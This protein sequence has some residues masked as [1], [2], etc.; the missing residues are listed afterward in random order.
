MEPKS[1]AYLSPEA[2]YSFRMA[3][4]AAKGENSRALELIEKY[5]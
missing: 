2:E 5:L 1:N 4:E 3:T